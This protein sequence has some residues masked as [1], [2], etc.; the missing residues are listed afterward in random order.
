M[1]DYLL[2]PGAEKRFAVTYLLADVPGYGSAL[3]SM[4]LIGDDI[5]AADFMVEERGKLTARQLGVR[6]IFSRI[7]CGRFGSLGS[8]RFRPAC[9]SDFESFLSYAYQNNFYIS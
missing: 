9:I 3:S 4:S 2:E 6:S 8:I 7:E 1:A 5:A